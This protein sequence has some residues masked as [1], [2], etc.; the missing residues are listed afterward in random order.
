MRKVLTLWATVFAMAAMAQEAEA[1]DY[2]DFTVDAE[3]R[4]LGEFR[5]GLGTRDDGV[6][7]TNL[8]VNDRV[9]LGFGWERK[10]IS[11]RIAAQHTGIWHDGSQK[12]TS[13]KITLHE[14][15]AKLEFGKGFFATAGRQELSL[16]DERLFGAHDWAPTGRAH[17]ALRLGWGNAKNQLQAIVSFNQTADVVGD[18]LYLENTTNAPRLYKNMQTLWYRFG[19]VEAPFRISLLLTNQG[20][21]DAS[22]SGTNYMQTFGT[23]MDFAKRKFFFDAS[24]YYQIGKDRYGDDV[25]AFMMSG[26]L[27]LQ[28]SPKWR[29]SI[30]DDYLSGGDGMPGTN[31]TF[32]LLYGSYHE[33]LGSMDY[34]GFG[35]LPLY[36]IND[37]NMKTVFTPN[38]KF[39]LSMALHW[40]STG[41]PINNYLRDPTEE[42]VDP[43]KILIMRRYNGKYRF[44][45]NLGT[46]LDVEVSYRPWR[47]ITFRGG[48]S[49]MVASQT[50]Q[51]FKGADAGSFHSWGW[52]S[53]DLNPTVFSTRHRRQ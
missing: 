2:G 50:M 21:G 34:F 1:P 15:W 53:F 7:A 48:L 44:P 8:L 17:D 18:V 27:G 47:D 4:A 28:F 41:R 22:G 23:Y 35:S 3:V 33:F 31:R 46:E 37:L 51:L 19:A 14:A 6:K 49:M 36:G 26:N 24:L 9:R 38:P 30:G 52:L 32:N 13:G 16:D 29:A 12:N 40:L 20:V 39:D 43:A 11:M 45:Q 25:R 5:T 10:N 42:I